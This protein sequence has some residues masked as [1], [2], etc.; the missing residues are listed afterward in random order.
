MAPEPDQAANLKLAP[1][2]K[3]QVKQATNREVMHSIWP[4]IV[5]RGRA[6]SSKIFVE[7]AGEVASQAN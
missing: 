4:V 1:P 3:E 2:V 7:L 6:L 5:V